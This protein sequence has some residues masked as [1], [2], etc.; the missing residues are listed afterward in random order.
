MDESQTE[1]G[2]YPILPTCSVCGSPVFD[3]KTAG[4]PKIGVV[5]II[6]CM[7]CGNIIGIIPGKETFKKIIR[8]VIEEESDRKESKF[9]PNIMQQQNH[10][11]N[12][13]LLGSIIQTAK[14]KTAI[15]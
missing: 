5:V 7:N 10:R 2:N 3:S 1:K 9:F 6:Y 4:F 12:T 14:E 11:E 13:T 15:E 8:E